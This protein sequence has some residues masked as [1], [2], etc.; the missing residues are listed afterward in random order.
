MAYIN[1]FVSTLASTE[2]SMSG[3]PKN[4]YANVFARY[5]TKININIFESSNIKEREIEHLRVSLGDKL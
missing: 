3:V 2:R 4:R 5:S 1:S